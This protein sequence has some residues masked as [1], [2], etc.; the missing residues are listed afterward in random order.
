MGWGIP[1]LT[2]IHGFY[3]GGGCSATHCLWI[4]WGGRLNPVHSFVEVE[5]MRSFG[6][7]RGSARHRL[8]VSSLSQNGSPASSPPLS[9]V[10][11]GGVLM[12]DALASL[13]LMKWRVGGGGGGFRERESCPM[14]WQRGNTHWN[15]GN[16]EEML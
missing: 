11:H 3:G 10:R 16:V 4:L 13:L 6:V 14:R 5:T 8:P 2:V 1:N 15:R 9:V 12:L 7:G